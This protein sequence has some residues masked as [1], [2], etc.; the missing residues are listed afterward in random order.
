MGLF[1]SHLSGGKEHLNIN[2]TNYIS[3]VR[4][5]F[6]L[7]LARTKITVSDTDATA[8]FNVWSAICHENITQ[9]IRNI[10]NRVTVIRHNST[11]AGILGG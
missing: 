11:M 1:I 7:I 4:I 9:L 3:C 5:N 10:S 2:I 8:D 6:R